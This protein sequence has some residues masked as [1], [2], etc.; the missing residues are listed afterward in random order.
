MSDGRDEDDLSSAWT[1]AP[2]NEAKQEGGVFVCKL[3]TGTP[4]P[5][6]EEHSW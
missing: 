2:N 5:E 6:G 4:F 1:A 3:L